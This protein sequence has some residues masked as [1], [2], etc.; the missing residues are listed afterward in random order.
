VFDSIR[1]G[2]NA[3]VVATGGCLRLLTLRDLSATPAL[4][5]VFVNKS[6]SAALSPATDEPQ[7]STV[8]G[9][10]EFAAEE[11]AAARR[12]EPAAEEP[13]AARRAEPAAEEPAAAR[14]AEPAAEAVDLTEPDAPEQAPDAPVEE[15][16]E[17]DEEA[18]MQ[19]DLTAAAPS[20]PAGRGAKRTAADDD[21]IDLT[22][23]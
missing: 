6:A 17:K 4:Q 2:T 23:D 1:G 15:L 5:A 22:G 10:G 21:E 13:A 3:T 7:P 20:P 9:V 16:A 18:E 19:I 11:P 12:A 14:R 8:Y